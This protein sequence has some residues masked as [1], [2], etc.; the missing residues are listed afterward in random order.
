MQNSLKN[1]EGHEKRNPLIAYGSRARNS[2]WIYKIAK[3]AGI[4]NWNEKG[5]PARFL[6]LS[7]YPD[8]GILAGEGN[9]ISYDIAYTTIFQFSLIVFIFRL[10]KSF[11]S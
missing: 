11:F 5:R 4:K 3:P 10:S 1:C 8:L 7:S 2:E 9:A 6:N